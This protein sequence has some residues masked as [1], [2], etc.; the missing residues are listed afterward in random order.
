MDER[1]RSPERLLKRVQA[2]ERQAQRGKLKIYI[3]AAPGVGKTYAMLQ[4]A[5]AQRQQGLDVIAGLVESHGRK[6]IEAFLKGFDILPRQQIEYHGKHL[7]EFDLDAAIKRNPALILIDEMA[8]PNVPGLRHAKRWQDIKEILDRGIDVYTTLNVQHIES[9]NDIVLQII[10]TR[11]KETIPDSALEFA[12]TI[13]LVDL[14]PED[15]LKRLQEGKVYFPAQ[16]TLA[17]EHFFQKGNLIALRE[18]VLR[19]T[20]QCVEAQ[21]LLHRQGQGIERIWPT[22]QRIL[23]CVGSEPE[24][25]QM[26][27]TAKRM[28]T[29]LQVEWIALHVDAPKL[30]LSEE[31]HALVLQNLR[32]AEILGAE[33][34]IITGLDVVKEIMDFA[35]EQN[36][37][38]IIVGKRI[39]QRWKNLFTRNL[40]DELI[41][42]SSEINFYIVSYQVSAAKRAIPVIHKKPISWRIYATT[43]GVVVL[44]TIIDFIL[45]NF[46]G[47]S[48]LIMVYLLGIIGVALYGQ[49]GPS[50]LASILS[51]LAYGF[52][53]GPLHFDFALTNIEYFFT[54]IVMLVV[55]L[56]ISNLTILSRRQ[57]Q[58]ANL[59]E[60]RTSALHTLSQ[61]LASTR[62][63]DKLLDISVRYLSELFECQVIALLPKN[64]RLEI[65][66]KY[67]AEAVLSDKEYSI[68]QWAYDLG[69]AAGLGTDTLAF[70]D[71]VYVPLLASQGPAGVLKMHPLQPNQQLTSD[72]MHLLEASANQI[73]LALEVDGLQEKTKRKEL[74]TETDRVRSAILQSVSHDLRAPLVAI[75]AASSTLMDMGSELD[76]NQVKQISSNI[77]TESEQ[78]SRLINNLL[79]ITYLEGA[80]IKLQKESYSLEEI[81]NSVLDALRMQL[82]DR[83]VYVQ[84]PADLPKIP[85]DNTLIQEVFI[86]LIDNAVKFTSPETPI[87]IV[88]FTAPEKIVVRVEDRGPGIVA[89]EID[90]LFEKFYRGRLLKTTGLGLGLAICQRIVKAHGGEIWAENR[91]NGG[92]AFCFSLPLDVNS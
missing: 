46:L 77:Y 49:L 15:L 72:Q 50:I 56:T 14:P 23:V 17:K 28:A 22:Q 69:Q 26:V 20:A 1:R 18:L 5:L 30:R 21:V 64:D 6:E 70:A 4:D 2:E 32:F 34:K 53:F 73:G 86:N 74:K 25:K 13:E 89:D 33:T 41:R 27:R 10:G 42:Q 55:A 29:N 24:S 62:G 48:S 66:A 45:N 60:R 8:H 61:K 83:Q 11:V 81:V 54:L 82:K 3:G 40:A 67:K 76:A 79:Q 7:T 35:R 91:K 38:T 57:T 78:L 52:F 37:T 12:D 92:A 39:R 85:L 84:I 31:Q 16:A 47:R 9:L 88:A 51:V 80:S 19:V 87:E 44:A 63:A 90:K 68:A 43:F 36:I 58:A 59:A 71:S 75:M 65:R